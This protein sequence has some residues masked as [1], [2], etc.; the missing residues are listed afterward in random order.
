MGIV[1]GLAG[2]VL[3]LSCSFAFDCFCEKKYGTRSWMSVLIFKCAK[4]KYFKFLTWN[5]FGDDDWYYEIVAER[6]R[7]KGAL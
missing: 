6:M 5:V 3:G 1:I 4:S 2:V 7:R